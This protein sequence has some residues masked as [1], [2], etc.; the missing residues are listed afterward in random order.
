MRRVRDRGQALAEYLM[1]VA[2]LVVALFLPYMGGESIAA[3]L[4]RALLDHF[5]GLSFVLS[6]L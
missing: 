5:R 2:A 6:V 3:V 4:A 1:V